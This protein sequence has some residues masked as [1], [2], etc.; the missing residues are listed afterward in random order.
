[1][2]QYTRILILLVTLSISVFAQEEPLYE[3]KPISDIRF[4]G[5]KTVS[6]NELLGLIRPYLGSAYTDSLSWEIQSKL[7]ALDYFNIIIPELRPGPSAPES[8][9]LIFQVKEKPQVE[10]VRFIGNSKVSR[11]VLANTVLVKSGDLLNPGSLGLD[12]QKIIDHYLEKGFI[13]A[14]VVASYSVDEAAN[15]A[16]VSFTI[17]EGNQTKISDIQFVGNDKHVS[18]R[19]LRSLMKTKVQSLFSRGLYVETKLQEDIKAI[20]QYYK[21]QGLIDVKI[22]DVNKEVEFDEKQGVGK[23]AVTIV[24]QEGDVWTYAGISLDGNSIYSDA[25]LKEVMLQQPGEVFHSSRFQTDVQRIENLYYENGYI[26]NTFA[27]KE[28][29]QDEQR[30]ISYEVVITERDRAHIESIIIRGNHK[31]KSYIIRRELPLEEGEVFSRSKILEGVGNLYNLQYFDAVEP[32]PYQ[33]DEDGLMDLVIDVEEG[34]TSDIGFGLSFSGGVDFPIS[35]QVS[36]TDRNFLGRGQIIGASASVS[37]NVQSVSLSFTEPRILGLRLSGGTEFRWTHSVNRRINL[38]LDGNGLPDP[39]ITW[40]EY[41]AAGRAVPSDH[42]MEYNSHFLSALFNTGYTWVTRLGRLGA[43]TGLRLAWEFVKYDSSVHRPHSRGIRE[44]L[45]TWKY[46]DSISLRVAWDTRDLQF[47]PTRGF[48]L[49]ETFT[50][51]G[52]LPVSRRDYM[53]SV[54]RFNFNQLLFS[55][56]VNDQ[57][58]AF[59]STLYFNTAFQAL[60]DKPWANRIADRQRDGFFIDGMFVG[61]G[62]EPHSGY[63]F[64]WDNTLQFI[65]PIAP[66]ILAFDIFLDAVGA[67][68]AKEGKYKTSNALSKMHINDWRF[69]LG[70]GFRFANPQFPIGIYLVKKFRWNIDGDID[71]NPEPNLTEFKNWG[72]DLVIAFKLDIY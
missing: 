45:E 43:S 27:Y 26:F 31:T 16:N 62:W 38:D 51:A 55:V 58:G 53:K 36:W 12:E 29:R 33:G 39:Y 54:T 19:K 1:M 9:E 5:L 57:G 23:L 3:G 70:G 17:V 11:G 32:Q 2:R 50:F 14:R 59:Q 71:W 20:E 60:F 30:K 61:R 21:D 68:V 69:S 67:W 10:D 28:I 18:D 44:N 42:Q 63:R 13:D 37:P 52:I 66:N 34:R 47:N 24:I 22:L 15:T 56:P 41:D 25:E 46:D 8:V 7:Y 72:M 49:S 48:I 4:E 40:N 65:F 6:E 35:G 64:L